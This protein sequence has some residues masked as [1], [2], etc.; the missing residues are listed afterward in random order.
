M[1]LLKG[2][3]ICKKEWVFFTRL[4]APHL[5]LKGYMRFTLEYNTEKEG[6]SMR[7]IRKKRSIIAGLFS[8]LIIFSILTNPTKK[9]YLLFSEE[10]TGIVTPATVEIERINFYLFST[11]APMRPLDHYGIVHLGF[12][13]KFFQISDGQFDHPWWLEFF[14]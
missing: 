1:N 11:Y 9:D 3:V 14:N 13:G 8:I 6:G 7:V 4:P 2:G 5:T 12:M 10:T